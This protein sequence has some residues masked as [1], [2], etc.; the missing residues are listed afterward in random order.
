MSGNMNKH[1]TVEHG[2]PLCL[3]NLLE[4]FEQEAHGQRRC[5]WYSLPGFPKGI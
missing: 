3:T 5:N 1:Y 2:I 4:C